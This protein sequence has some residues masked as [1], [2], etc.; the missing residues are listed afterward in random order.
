M[1][2]RWLKALLGIVL[3]FDV[4]VFGNAAYVKA[5]LWYQLHHQHNTGPCYSYRV[6]SAD[7]TCDLPFRDPSLSGNGAGTWSKHEQQ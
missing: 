7:E 6:Y 3:V 4:L 2:S 5:H 1:M